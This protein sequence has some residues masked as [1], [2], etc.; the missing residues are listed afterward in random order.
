[1]TVAAVGPLG[2]LTAEGNM[3]YRDSAGNITEVDTFTA[4]DGEVLT[5]VAGVP[6]WAAPSLAVKA[7]VGTDPNGVIFQTIGALVQAAIEVRDTFPIIAFDQA[8]DEG[9]LWELEMPED[10][11][12]GNL[13]VSIFW[14]SDGTAGDVGWE[15]QFERNEAGH[16]ITAAAFAAAQSITDASAAD[17]EIVEAIIPFTNAQADLLAGGDPF[18]FLLARDIAVGSNLLADAQVLYLTITED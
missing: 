8:T 9:A 16:V 14:T 4:T 6:A 15:G 7:F 3:L 10:Y 2:V 13:S 12:G 11:D 17:G 5:R 18:R 1:M